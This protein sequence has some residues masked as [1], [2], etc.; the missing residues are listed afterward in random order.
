MV[1]YVNNEQMIQVLQDGNDGDIIIKKSRKCANTITEEYKI[2]A[3][4]F[5]TMLNWYKHQK[6]LGNENL[7]F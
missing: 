4:D 7:N 2:E 6:A 3:G 1:F 5:I